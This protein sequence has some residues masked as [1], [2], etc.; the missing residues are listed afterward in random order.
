[1]EYIENWEKT[2]ERFRAFWANEVIDRCCVAA[3]APKSGMQ[4]NQFDK[5]DLKK[6]WTDAEF[7]LERNEDYFEKTRYGGE[8]FPRIWVNLG[9]GITAAYLGCEANMAED[10]IWFTPF[11]NDWEKDVFR[12]NPESKW[13]GITRNLTRELSKAGKDKFLVSITDLSGTA[14]IMCHMRGTENLC[15]DMLESPD[16]VKSARDYIM[17]VL[18]DCYD[19]LYDTAFDT[20]EGST[21][22]LNLWAPGKHLILQ[23]DF[24]TMLSPM[25][26]EKFFLPEIQAQCKHYEYPMYHLDGPEEI[27][28]LDLLL[29]IPELKAIQW[30]PIPG[31]GDVREWMPLFRKIKAAGKA[32]YFAVAPWY[33]TNCRDIEYVLQELP[34]EGLFIDTVCETEEEFSWLMNRLDRWS[35]RRK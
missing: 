25:M 10:T 21:H 12:F 27:K 18:F 2:K 15:L 32:L 28:H 1:M 13:W 6:Y 24:C 31:R 4:Y 7:I 30:V 35:C 19:E 17:K 5:K 23:C 9:P 33:G 22:W 34:P 11:I 3:T 29:Q 20:T 16:A 26:F 8:A 14:D